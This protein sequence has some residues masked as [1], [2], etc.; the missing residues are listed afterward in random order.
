MRRGLVEQNRYR[1]DW[2]D[3][4]H[5]SPQAR[6]PRAGSSAYGRDDS[7][8]SGAGG[9]PGIPVWSGPAIVFA[10]LVTGLLLSLASGSVSTAYLVCF[11]VAGVAVA[12]L[13]TARGLFLTVASIPLLFGVLTP[14]ASWLVNQAGTGAAQ[15]FSTTA[16]V[17]AVYPLTQFF[18]VLA[19]VTVGAAV[20]AVLR[21]WLLKRRTRARAAAVRET[22]RRN[23]EAERRNRDTTTRA[24]R[25]STRTRPP[26]SERTGERV[27]V[28]ELMKRNPRRSAP[29]DRYEA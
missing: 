22:R 12:L 26:R 4:S 7:Q 15:G 16:V 29:G 13:T 1:L 8:R 11:V 3:V 14:V 6:K 27:T 17:T 25:Q 23:A 19:A 9:F 18:P 28:E 10:A 24:R 20:I 21:L 5:V 2:L